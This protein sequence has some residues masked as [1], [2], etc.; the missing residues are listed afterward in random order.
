LRVREI[1]AVILLYAHCV[2]LDSGVTAPAAA[3]S[4]ASDIRA[5]TEQSGLLGERWNRLADD[6]IRW[7]RAPGHDSYWRFHR[8]AF[9]ELL[10]PAGDRTVDIGCG[11][12]RVTRDLRKAGHEVI[13]VDRSPLM[14]SA[15]LTHPEPS[16]VVIG[17][18]RQ[19][20]LPADSADC[21][22]A[23]MSLQDIDNMEIAVREVARILMP[24][25]RF[26]IA[27]VHPI[28]SGG[29]FLDS[30]GEDNPFAV[31]KSYFDAA[32]SSP[33]HA[34]GD[35]TMVFHREHRPLRAYTQALTGAGF[36]IEQLNELTDPDKPESRR[37]IPM[38][39]DILA[40]LR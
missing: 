7:A 20:P 40:T 18:A 10:P 24:N 15:A 19:L 17:D 39:L 30:Q 14:C 2:S 22:V 21:A 35:L 33:Q 8:D 4:P 6:W 13:G 27:I 5:V 26:V 31:D 32:P 34:Q 12:G 9:F 37:G 16:R 1:T 25:G 29:H 23:F 11:E 3:G 36:V 38:F 28:Y